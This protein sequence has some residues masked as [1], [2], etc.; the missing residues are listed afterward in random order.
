M[1][2]HFLKTRAQDLRNFASEAAELAKKNPDD[3]WLQAAAKN[4]TQA[5][6][7]AMRELALAYRDE[8]GE[9]LDL[10]FIGPTADGSIPL[11]AFIKIAGPLVKAW[12]AAA[13]RIRHGLVHNRITG[14]IGDTLNLKLAGLG[15]GST[16]VYVTGS[17]NADLAGESLLHATLTQ[18]FRLL[19]TANDEFYDAVDAVGSKAAQHFGEAM[20][21]I[22]AA[23]LSTEFTW[24]DNGH[25]TVWRG[26]SDEVIRIKV[27]LDAVATPESYEEVVSG[28]ISAITDTGRL[29]LRT[30]AGR[31]AVRFPLDL[32]ETVQRLTIAKQASLRVRTT[33]YR[34]AVSKK[35]IYKRIMLDVDTSNLK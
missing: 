22:S 18:T 6:Q 11:D 24:S 1:S 32:T 23:G 27:L 7:A 9:L 4:Q 31:I 35:D 20:R 13:H 12:Q 34:D 14:D 29:E 3:F 33:K 17:S 5:S 30:P 28:F 26:T 16:R 21:A 19:N 10:R 15:H 2:I 8:A 25:P